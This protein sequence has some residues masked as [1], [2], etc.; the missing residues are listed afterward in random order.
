MSGTEIEAGDLVCYVTNLARTKMYGVIV[1]IG[2]LQYTNPR[3][4]KKYPAGSYNTLWAIWTEDVDSSVESYLRADDD[5]LRPTGEGGL[6]T[7]DFMANDYL[8]IWKSAEKINP[9]T[10]RMD[11]VILEEI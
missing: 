6:M 9:K 11:L 5:M 2:P 10:K 1:F 3:D 7:M 8:I 4:G